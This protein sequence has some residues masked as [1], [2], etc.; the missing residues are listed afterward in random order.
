MNKVLKPDE[1]IDKNMSGGYGGCLFCIYDDAFHSEFY[2]ETPHCSH[3][4][5]PNADLLFLIRDHESACL[6][7]TIKV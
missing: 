3:E 1:Q 7:K 2:G 6:Y 5:N 4:P